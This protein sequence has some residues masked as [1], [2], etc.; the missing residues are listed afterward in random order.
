METNIVIVGL[1]LLGSSIASAC[2]EK[3]LPYSVIGV[4]SPSTLDKALKKNIIHNSYG[5][6]DFSWVAHADLIILC[7]PISHIMQ[8]LPAIAKHQK[9]FKPNL[10]VTDVGSTKQEIHALANSCMPKFF[11]GSHPMAGS[12]KKGIQAADGTLFES[13]LW[14]IC[15][16]QPVPILENFVTEIGAHATYLEPKVH[17]LAVAHVSHLPQLLSTALAS[18]FKKES[19][20]YLDFAGPGFRDMSRLAESSYEMWEPIFKT[21]YISLKSAISQFSSEWEK[22]KDKLEQDQDIRQF[23]NDGNETRSRVH[24]PSPEIS[25]LFQILIKVA[26]QPGMINAI[27]APLTESNLD[28]RDIELMKNREGAGGTLRLAFDHLDK[29]KQAIKLLNDLKFEAHLR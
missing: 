14:I 21:N 25:G 9:K 2:K 18:S 6:D 24:N 11:I 1:G 7:T 26:D 5:Y 17:D 28:I 8:Y 19:L 4:S 16:H 22:L 10:L 20:E 23:F 15:H 12:E 3:N 27:I 13:T 29:A